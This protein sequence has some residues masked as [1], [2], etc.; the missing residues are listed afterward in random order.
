MKLIIDIPDDT[1]KEIKDNAMFAES[2]A[3]RLMM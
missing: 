1:A 3:L 2:I